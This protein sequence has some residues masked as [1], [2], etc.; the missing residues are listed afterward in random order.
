MC[1]SEE[2][3][4]V[5]ARHIAE[6]HTCA[7][8]EVETPA[9]TGKSPAWAMLSQRST[10]RAS[11]MAWG[12][13]SGSGNQRRQG[14]SWHSHRW[15]WVSLSDALNLHTPQLSGG[16]GGNPV[17]QGGFAVQQIGCCCWTLQTHRE[18]PLFHWRL[19]AN[20]WWAF[21]YLNERLW[22]CAFK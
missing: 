17:T 3:R 18:N 4:K 11:G 7:C 9:L 12:N 1:Y 20:A 15:H 2:R 16:S 8:V 6:E 13:C 10:Q 14:C 21:V 5:T 22:T 19:R